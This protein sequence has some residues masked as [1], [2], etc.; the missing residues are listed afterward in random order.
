MLAGVSRLRRAR[1]GHEQ[2]WHGAAGVSSQWSDGSIV[3]MLAYQGAWSAV[4]MGS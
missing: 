1:L 2:D 4:G 3:C